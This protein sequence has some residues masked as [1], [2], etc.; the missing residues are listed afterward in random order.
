MQP[1]EIVE[2]ALSR[3]AGQDMAVL[4]DTSSQ[5]NLRWAGNSLT[6]NGNTQGLD[7][8][9]VAFQALGDGVA[10][11]TVTGQV[12]DIAGL[13]D[14]VDR[15]RAAA[16]AAAPADEAAPLVDGGVSAD[17]DEPPP[18]TGAS[19]LSAVAVGLGE[20]FRR[21]RADGVQH[22][23]YAEH[24]LSTTYLGTTAGTRLRHSQATGR[25]ELTAKSADGRRS[26][27]H[28][29]A[30]VS[31]A[32]VELDDIDR[33]LRQRLSWQKRRVDVAP[34]R[35]RVLLSPSAVADLMIDLYWSADAQSAIQ[36]R[37]AFSRPGGGTRVGEHLGGDV[38]LFSDPRADDPSLE[39]GTFVTAAA[40]SS[41]SSP[42]D[43]GLPLTPTRW[44][45]G[46]RLQ[47]LITTRHT[48]ALADLSDSP[49]IDN[50]MLQHSDGGGSL[51]DVVAR[52]DNGLLVT[53][54][55]YNRVVDPQTMLLTGLTRDGVYVVRDGEVAGA[56]GNFRFNESPVALLGRIVDSGTPERT[57]ARE[58]GDYFNRA[59]MPPL[60]VADFNMSTASEAM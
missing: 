43:N 14:L 20:A 5:V 40:S 16:A 51:S 6:T 44:I 34:G 25:L 48:A 11:A 59:T 24:D 29:S 36:G 31:L 47:H 58:M 7:V 1:Q 55:W 49:G 2:R 19:E 45:D 12:R 35:H 26:A 15:A 18:A 50:L 22:F 4:V 56:C 57:L 46:G 17:W 60:L 30:A 39:C 9:I 3:A 42:F 33:Q 37:S 21:G 38:T 53:C 13:D 27:W 41:T 52:M 28:G 10:T 23:G 8:D 32:D 54:L